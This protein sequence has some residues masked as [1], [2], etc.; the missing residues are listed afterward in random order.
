MPAIKFRSNCSI[1]NENGI[2]CFL[3]LI[4]DEAVFR[5][6]LIKQFENEN[7]DIKIIGLSL[8][9]KEIEKIVVKQIKETLFKEAKTFNKS[10]Y[11]LDSSIKFSQDFMPL[12]DNFQAILKNEDYDVFSKEVHSLDQEILKGHSICAALKIGRVLEFVVLTL[13]HSWDIKI[14]KPVIKIID[15]LDGNFS[16]LKNVLI[17]Y[18]YA[19]EKD[20]K[21]KKSKL[22]QR[23]NEISNKLF[24]LI[25]DLEEKT[26]QDDNNL[27][28]IN[29]NA[30]LKEVG[31]KYSKIVAVRE[32]LNIL[33]KENYIKS[34]M[35]LRNIAAHANV[36][37]MN[38]DLE[39]KDIKEMKK[40][41]LIVLLHLSNINNAIVNHH[42]TK[43]KL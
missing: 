21:V 33:N 31:K 13:A 24:E 15:D 32:E 4:S 6:D 22:V 37:G 29:L 16:G 39:Y 28:P 35:E 26:T 40:N 27:I 19:E 10:K 42:G 23:I 12:L 25:G 3:I 14:N 8:K 7:P 38:K 43:I 41:L 18:T 2:I 17:D 20:K 11:K 36:N 1:F 5:K 30:A 9:R 34:L